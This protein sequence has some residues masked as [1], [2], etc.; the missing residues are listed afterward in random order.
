M[1]G[2]GD[3]N[4][5][6]ILEYIYDL[7]DD[8]GLEDSSIDEMLKKLHISADCKQDLMSILHDQLTQYT[9]DD[10]LAEVQLGGVMRSMEVIRR[11]VVYGRKKTAEN[12]QRARCRVVRPD[13]AEDIHQLE[14]TI[15][16][17]ARTSC[18]SRTLTTRSL[19]L[20]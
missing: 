19:T 5:R 12:L 18:T 15:G 17:C 4:W 11:A 20:T 3:R 7:D 16:G 1:S 6:H 8:K 10:L 13:I 2:A 14:D 9:K